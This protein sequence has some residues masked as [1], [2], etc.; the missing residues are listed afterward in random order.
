MRLSQ[1]C[2]I[3]RLGRPF[4]GFRRSFASKISQN[5]LKSPKSRLFCTNPPR[6]RHADE[7]RLVGSAGD[8]GTA[9]EAAGK[10]LQR[11]A[12]E[13]REL[14]GFKR[15]R[16]V[17]LDHILTEYKAAREGAVKYDTA[18]LAEALRAQ[19]AV[20]PDERRASSRVPGPGESSKN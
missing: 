3:C 7:I 6:S 4:D 8:G 19:F 14:A 12:N 18:D 5:L 11:D 15:T 17:E 10:R 16:D 2:L 13:Q 9:A 1:N 20:F